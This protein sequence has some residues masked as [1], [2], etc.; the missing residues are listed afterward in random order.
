MVSSRQLLSD[1]ML[2]ELLPTYEFFEVLDRSVTLKSE[3][4][5]P[6]P[7]DRYLT[8]CVHVNEEWYD[9]L[10]SHCTDEYNDE[11]LLPASLEHL[12]NNQWLTGPD[13]AL[14]LGIS[15]Q[16]TT[17]AMCGQYVY[18]SMCFRP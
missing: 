16:P 3:G 14:Y 7:S 8:I 12:V 4:M 18:I 15:H 1:D 9:L 17:V 2:N 10:D 11:L 13:L 6:A 5:I